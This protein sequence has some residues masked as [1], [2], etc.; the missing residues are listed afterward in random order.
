MKTGNNQQDFEVADMIMGDKSVIIGPWEYY[1]QDLE[2]DDLRHSYLHYVVNQDTG[3]VR[4]VNYTRHA[5]MKDVDILRLSVM[6]WPEPEA[7]LGGCALPW[8][9][10]TIELALQRYENAMSKKGDRVDFSE[11]QPRLFS[12]AWTL[13]IFLLIA[14]MIPIFA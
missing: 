2:D 7:V 5:L 14:I 13:A 11:G 1:T 12:S 9:S 4:E 3:V 8:T 6:N 10:A